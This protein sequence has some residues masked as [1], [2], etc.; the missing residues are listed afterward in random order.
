MS[1]KSIEQITAEL[2]ARTP[3]GVTVHAPLPLPAGLG[4]PVLTPDRTE[5]T[6]TE[7]LARRKTARHTRYTYLGY[8]CSRSGSVSVTLSEVHGAGLRAVPLATL[9][10]CGQVHHGYERGKTLALVAAEGKAKEGARR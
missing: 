8:S 9:A 3:A 4:K 7:H 2:V 6:L 5:V 10:Q 1:R